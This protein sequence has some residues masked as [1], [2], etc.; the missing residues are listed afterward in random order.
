MGLKPPDPNGLDIKLGR[1]LSVGI[2][3]ALCG[4][5]IAGFQQRSYHEPEHGRAQAP[6]CQAGGLPQDYVHTAAAGL[7][8]TGTFLPLGSPFTC[9]AHSPAA[10]QSVCA[11][12]SQAVPL[13][14]TQDRHVLIVEAVVHAPASAAALAQ[15]GFLPA[16]L[17]VVQQDGA[18]ALAEGEGPGHGQRQAA[19]QLTTHHIGVHHVPVVVTDA[20]PGAPV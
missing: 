19:A 7:V 6:A 4:S 17:H 15:G 10:R 11:S 14:V 5:S 1:E 18:S 2:I 13:T 3:E 9:L 12:G 8:F 16:A 20:A